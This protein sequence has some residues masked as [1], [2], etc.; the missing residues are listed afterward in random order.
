MICLCLTGS[1]ASGKT[2]AALEL[3]RHLPIE[4]VSMDSALVYRGMDIGTAKPSSQVRATVPHHLIDIAEPTE[5][6][7]AGRFVVDAGEAVQAIVDRGRVPLLVGGTLLYLR[8]FTRGLARLPVADPQLRQRLD[9]EAESVGW[10]ALHARL[11]KIDPDAAA[12]IAPTDR[13]RIQRALEVAEITGEPISALQRDTVPG[14]HPSSVR[15]IAIV[16]DDR[17]GLA[18]RIE[19]R[20]D[21]MVAAGFVGEVEALMARG[22]LNAN[23]PSMRAVGYRQLWSYLA[24]EASWAEARAR[25]LAAT[26]QLAKRQ[27]TWIRAEANLRVLPWS[28]PGR[29]QTI[30]DWALEASAEHH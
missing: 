9:A 19:H 17:A 13:Q 16:D 11:A 26:R 21:A 12:R 15:T 23:L 10:P 24:G 5:A 8:A 29:A 6:Y 3:A 20:F 25:A 2:D 7:S 18:R 1:T 28:Y 14:L 27:M 4:I 22:D 30:V